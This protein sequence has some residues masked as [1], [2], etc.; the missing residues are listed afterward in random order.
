MDVLV[1]YMTFKLYQVLDVRT[2]GLVVAALDAEPH[3]AGLGSKFAENHSNE[4]L[5]LRCSTATVVSSAATAVSLAATAVSS[6]DL[7][8]SRQ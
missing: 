6:A 2:P 7:L 1:N 3:L 5:R 8:I 4:F